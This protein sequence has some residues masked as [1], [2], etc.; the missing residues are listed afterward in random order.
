MQRLKR[1]FSIDIETCPMCGGTP[2]VIAYIKDPDLIA[3]IL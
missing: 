2:R 1:V 3:T